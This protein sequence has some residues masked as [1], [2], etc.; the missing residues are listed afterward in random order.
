MKRNLSKNV[1]ARIKQMHVEKG[2]KQLDSA[3]KIGGED[4]SLRR[5][6]S[7]RTNP[8]FKTLFR[9]AVAIDLEVINLFAPI[10]EEGRSDDEVDEILS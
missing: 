9:I 3:S 5:I 8:I 6:E 4:S 2:M 1:G 10:N 7:G